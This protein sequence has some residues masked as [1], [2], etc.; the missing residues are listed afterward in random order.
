M[1]PAGEAILALVCG[2]GSR[3]LRRRLLAMFVSYTD[4][5][6]KGGRIFVANTLVS[7]PE[8]WIKFSDEWQG[9][10]D[11][12]PK[13]EFCKSSQLIPGSSLYEKLPRLIQCL[14]RYVTFGTCT[15]V[16]VDKYIEYFRNM[17][18]ISFDSAFHH[19]YMHTAIAAAQ[20]AAANHPGT[21]IDYVFDEIGDTEFLEL[22]T[23]LRLFKKHS[24]TRD[25]A[26]CINPEITCRDDKVIKPLQGADLIAGAIRRSYEDGDKNAKALLRQITFPGD[27]HVWDEKVLASF[28]L[29]M[30][31]RSRYFGFFY[32]GGKERSKRLKPQR[33][34]L[35]SNKRRGR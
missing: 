18:S 23:G 14:N 17:V 19:A 10:L 3:D 35:K 32:E 5:S 2:Y 11:T 8:K 33:K 16:H 24:P 29:T 31:E 6:G 28:F 4:E 1:R 30:T 15:L 34:A 7:T 13:V 12:P 21:V 22:R 27:G 26:D 20:Y 25:I 9:I